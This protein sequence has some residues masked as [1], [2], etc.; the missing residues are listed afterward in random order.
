MIET[1]KKKRC[2][3]YNFDGKICRTVGDRLLCG[4]NRNVGSQYKHEEEINL[5]NG[6]KIKKG[7][8]ECGYWEP[9]YANTRRPPMWDH[10]DELDGNHIGKHGE[11]HLS[12]EEHIKK[13]LVTKKPESHVTRCVEIKERIVCRHI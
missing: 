7:R 10:H 5:N 8:L 1:H 3:P 13:M 12:S 9:P 11:K 2:C 4:Y 6:C